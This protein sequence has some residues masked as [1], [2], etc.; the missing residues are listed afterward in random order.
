VLIAEG[1]LLVLTDD[2]GKARVDNT[3]LT[4]ALA[5]AVLLELSLLGKVDV[6]ERGEST[7]QGR[8]IVRDPAPTGNPVLDLGLA[9]LERRQNKK[10]RDVIRHLA[11]GIR[12]QVA[13]LLVHAGAVRREESRVLGVFRRTRYPV[14]DDA[15]KQAVVTAM[16]GA[17]RGSDAPVDARVAGTISL[18]TAIDAL[19]RVVTPEMTGLT[20]RQIKRR[21][22]EISDGSWAPQA[23]K[24]AVA[25][26]NA[27][28]MAGVVAATTVATTSG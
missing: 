21:G 15:S 3:K 16:A 10:P 9:E 11:K 26:V 23:V 19:H 24:D 27:A 6:A 8:L 4:Y 2:V 25:A 17:V 14:I 5:G 22:K 7:K 20:S 12:E 1:T 13:T 28:V 18:L